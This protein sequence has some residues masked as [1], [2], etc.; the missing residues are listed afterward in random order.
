MPDFDP[1]ETFQKLLAVAPI[2]TLVLAVFGAGF[3]LGWRSNQ[4]FIRHLKNCRGSN[5]ENDE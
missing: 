4:P 2:A 1:I 5:V 3:W